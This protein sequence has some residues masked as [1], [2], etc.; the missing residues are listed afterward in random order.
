MILNLL[1]VLLLQALQVPQIPPPPPPVSSTASL[2]V[3][4]G[5]NDGMRLTVQDPEFSGFIEGR[6]GDAVLMYRERDFHGDMPLKT[7]SRIEFGLYRRGKPFPLKVMLR[8]GEQL[9]VES[10]RR[11]FMTLR[12]RTDFGIVTVRHPDP[13]SAPLRVTTRKP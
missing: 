8:N 10:E 11:D 1:L 6:S 13:V 5:L 12:G 2:T 4:V 3:V 9:D 7:V